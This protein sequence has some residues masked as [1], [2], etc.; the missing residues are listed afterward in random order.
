MNLYAA[1]RSTRV[2]GESGCEV[3]RTERDARNR[4]LAQVLGERER[5]DPRGAD[6]LKRT[7]RPA[8]L[9]N[10]RAFNQTRA[11]VKNHRLE[12]RQVRSEE[13]TSELQSQSNLVCRLL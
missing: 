8:S 2:L 11:R 1:A 10:A 12:G 4:A 5:I 6:E 3:N 9:G 7:R 13:H